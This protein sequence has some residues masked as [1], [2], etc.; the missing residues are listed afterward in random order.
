MLFR[1][2]QWCSI[3]GVLNVFEDVIIVVFAL[4]LVFFAWR[5]VRN[6]IRERRSTQSHE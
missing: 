6:L 2:D 1:S 5:W 4:M 3:L